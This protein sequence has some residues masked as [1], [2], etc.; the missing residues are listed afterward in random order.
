MKDTGIS[1]DLI[2]LRMKDNHEDKDESSKVENYRIGSVS[3][4]SVFCGMY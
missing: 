2:Y 3:G 1:R 4:V